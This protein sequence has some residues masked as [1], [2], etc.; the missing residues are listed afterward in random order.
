MAQA[1][2]YKLKLHGFLQIYFYPTDMAC[3]LFDNKG[4]QSLLPGDSAVHRQTK[5]SDS[6]LSLIDMIA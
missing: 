6:S 5:Q 2:T 3:R 4:V 1:K